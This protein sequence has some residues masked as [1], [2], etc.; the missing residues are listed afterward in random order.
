VKAPKVDKRLKA[1]RHANPDKAKPIG[2]GSKAGRSKAG[3]PKAAAP[4]AQAV[5][6]CP[7][8]GCNIKKVAMGMVIA[9]RL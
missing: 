7:C 1:W 8:C 9:E 2:K 3:R 4:V 6:F 5:N